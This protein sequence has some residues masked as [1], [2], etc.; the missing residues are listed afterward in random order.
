MGQIAQILAILLAF[1]FGQGVLTGDAQAETEPDFS[2]WGVQLGLPIAQVP[3]SAAAV[4][5]CGTKGGPAS[6]ELA[7]FANWAQCPAEPT[8][9]HEVQFSYDDEKDYIARALESEY[10]ALAGGTSM[11]A[12][13]VV[14]AILVDDA[15]LA[16]AVRIITDDRVSNN[17]RR[18]AVVLSRNM[19]VRFGSWGL[20]CE[21]I[22]MK[23]G[24]MKVGNEFIHEICRG[25]AA[26]G[27]GQQVLIEAS[28]LRKKGQDAISKDTQMVNKSYY[29]S[30][31]WVEVANPPY[32]PSEAP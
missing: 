16:Q 20:V 22:P 17:D 8:G 21:D 1:G 26:D 11:Y 4:I 10:R 31:T 32:S 14:V 30:K 15:G 27:S 23:D 12:H 3:N 5:S 29:E 19:K 18:V 13:P 24:E 2:I 9:L 28:Y 7:S 25:T 6:I